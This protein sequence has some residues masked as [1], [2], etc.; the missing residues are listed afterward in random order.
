MKELY[1][2]QL[3]SLKN[4]LNE[5]G[6][7]IDIS[8]E[9]YSLTQKDIKELREDNISVKYYKYN[10]NTFQTAYCPIMDWINRLY[11]EKFSK[12]MNPEEFVKL[13]GVYPYQEEVISGYLRNGICIR[14]QKIILGEVIYEE[15]RFIESLINIIKYIAKTIP[16]MLEIGRA[17]CRERV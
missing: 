6:M 13:C 7:F 11:K 17:S 9:K 15:E 5:G 8:N 10:I 1:L 4:N 14:E 3:Q 2:K 16:I 12:K